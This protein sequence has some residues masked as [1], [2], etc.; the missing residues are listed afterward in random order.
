MQRFRA[1]SVRRITALSVSAAAVC[2]AAVVVP[3]LIKIAPASAN[4]TSHQAPDTL[5]STTLVAAPP[6]GSKGPDDITVLR[7]H[8]FDHGRPIIWTAFQNGIG[9][10]GSP[11]G[12]QSTVAG[13]DAKSGTLLKTIAVTGKVDG[14][15]A[16]PKLGGLIATVN[17]DDNSALNVVDVVSG[18]VT[19]Y[20]YE[21]DPAV[22][23]SG[24]TDSIAV[25]GGQIYVTHSNPFDTFQ[26]AEYQVSLDT[27]SLAAT[28]RPVFF[29]DSRAKD[30]TTGATVTL[31]LTDPD[32]NAILPKSAHRFGG[33][34]ATVSQA[35]GQIVFAS[36]FHVGKPRLSLLNLSDNKAGNKPP[37]D[38]F[39]VATADRGTL[40]VV[41]NSAGTIEALDTAGWPAGTVFVG[42]PNDNG[43]PLV[44]ALNLR[45]GLITP[46]ANTFVNPKGIL[47]VPAHRHHGQEGNG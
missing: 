43:N 18:T 14:L 20:Q 36:Q 17:E 1:A 32:T 12:A 27:A 28:L 3:L 41:D 2:S 33:R 4:G 22:N 44:G 47:F 46:F 30:V 23:G 39:A 7:T 31:G 16:D 13:Y 29:D 10:D 40:Y 6:T 34:L 19:T 38:G 8:G 45:T 24:G 26:P 11:A 37:I 5:P 42:E 35:D 21:P 25:R 9:A 15:T